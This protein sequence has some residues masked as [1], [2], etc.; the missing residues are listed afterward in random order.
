M[1]TQRWYTRGKCTEA[2][3]IVDMNDLFQDD[4]FQL[5]KP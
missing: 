2:E 5:E 1:T 4:L 3:P